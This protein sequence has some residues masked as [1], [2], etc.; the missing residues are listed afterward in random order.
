MPEVGLLVELD[1]DEHERHVVVEA[2]EE[3]LAHDRP[4]ADRRRAR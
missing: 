2:G 1:V 4:R 3:R